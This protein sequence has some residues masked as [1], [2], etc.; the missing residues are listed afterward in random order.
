MVLVLLT[1]LDGDWETVLSRREWASRELSKRTRRT[2]GLIEID[3]QMARGVR[4]IDVKVSPGWG[5]IF[6]AGLVRDDHEQ[7]RFVLF[8][9]CIEPVF[10]TSDFE[11][12]R[13]GR[14]L[15]VFHAQ[16]IRNRH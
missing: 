12:D 2:V 1:C 6:A 10:L 11:F 13:A 16:H 14:T 9:D 15:G 5:G 7:A 4:R 3:D 8:C